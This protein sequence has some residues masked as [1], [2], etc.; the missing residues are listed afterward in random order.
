M[1]VSSDLKTHKKISSLQTTQKLGRWNM[2]NLSQLVAREM[3]SSHSG[4]VGSFR[5][6]LGSSLRLNTRDFACERP[7][8]GNGEEIKEKKSL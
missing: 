6:V 8:G 5:P 2:Y 7:G 3:V 4:I 1:V